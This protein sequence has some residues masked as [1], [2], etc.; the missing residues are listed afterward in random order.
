[1]KRRSTVDSWYGT[2]ISS[3]LVT[4]PTL[5]S[6]LLVLLILVHKSQPFEGFC[7]AKNYDLSLAQVI[8][9]RHFGGIN[10]P[11]GGVGG[12]ARELADGLVEK[13]GRLQ[14]KANVTEILMQ[15]GKAVGLVSSGL[16]SHLREEFQYWEDWE[17][18][19]LLI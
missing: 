3:F 16:T 12:I 9:D 15:D 10:Y 5:F 14:Y 11:K 1:M 7:K 18:L 4:L 6:D 8:C 19:Q 2:F 13:G 17:E